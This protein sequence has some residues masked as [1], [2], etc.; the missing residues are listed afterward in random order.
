MGT[1]DFSTF[2][3]CFGDCYAPEDS[4]QK[5]NFDQDIGGCVGTS[6][7]AAFVGCFGDSCA[8]CAGCAGPGAG[9][10]MRT[11]VSNASDP[12]QD[13]IEVRLVPRHS[14][15]NEDIA[16][17]LPCSDSFVGVGEVI[18]LEIWAR[19]AILAKN[20]TPGLATAYLD[21]RFD[22][23]LL[24]L[25]DVFPSMPFRLFAQEWHLDS[26]VLHTVG[27]CAELGHINV[28]SNGDWVKV[29][30]VLARAIAPGL[31]TAAAK[32]SDELHGFARVGEFQNT[33]ASLLDCQSTSFQIGKKYHDGSRR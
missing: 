7:F 26:R 10:L 33:D 31:V 9:S 8:A 2:A 18:Y 27:G 32:P 16:A 21:L 29:A 11:S 20:S 23:A 13:P 22:R 4:C 12:R 25:V 24:E 28:G 6:D 15:S 14:A 5:S 17:I 1:G 3:P 19:V 30:T